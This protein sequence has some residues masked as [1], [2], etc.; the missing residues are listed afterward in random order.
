M[1]AKTKTGYRIAQ[2]G[3]LLRWIISAALLLAALPGVAHRGHAVWTDIVW[4]GESFEIV[5]RI[6]LADAI[7][8]NRYMGGT[9]SIEETRSLARVALYVEERFDDGDPG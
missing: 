3:T 1:L 9:E 6:H 2:A 8:V 7:A 4:A 5:H